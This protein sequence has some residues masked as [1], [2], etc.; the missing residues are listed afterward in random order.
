MLFPW[1]SSYQSNRAPIVDAGPNLSILS[2]DQPVTTITGFASDADGDSLSYRWFEGETEL[3]SATP[4]GL[5]GDAPLNLGQLPPLSVGDHLLT[6]EVS[7]GRL[8]TASTMTLA[9]GDSPPRVACSGGGTFQAGI[10]DVVLEGQV[11]DFDGGVLDFEWGEDRSVHAEGTQSVEP[12]GTPSALPS[13]RLLTAFESRSGVLGIGRHVLT[14]S[15]DDG[16]NVPVMCSV[17]VDVVDT[18]APS[19]SP[20]SDRLILWP[21]NHQ[22]VDVVIFANAFDRSGGPVALEVAVASTEDALK[23]GSGQTIPDYTEPVIDRERGIITL[24]LRAERSGKGR[25]RTYTITI[26]GT[27]T[28]G[29]QSAASVAI[30]APHDRR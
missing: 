6:L 24:H 27:D 1:V 21:P 26:T 3:L 11:A 16:A 23:D 13:A 22:L 17:T 15:V 18:D 9:I 29:N 2:S 25:G 12:G 7:D 8:R 4:V 19:L 10:G 30:E 20:V 5:Q 28:A 14:L